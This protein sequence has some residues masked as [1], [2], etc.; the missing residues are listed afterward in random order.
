MES[1]SSSYD[2]FL[3]LLVP[4]NH[5]WCA[6]KEQIN[7]HADGHQLA[8]IPTCRNKGVVRDVSIILCLVLCVM[9]TV[10]EIVEGGPP[11]DI[12]SAVGITL[13]LTDS[14]SVRRHYSLRQA[15]TTPGKM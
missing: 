11:G 6:F 12:C 5:C 1:Q 4:W 3:M 10:V 8:V 2:M 13:T 14:N 9:E 15:R 7:C